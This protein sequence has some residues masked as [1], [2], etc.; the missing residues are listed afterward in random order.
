MSFIPKGRVKQVGE[1]RRVNGF[2]TKRAYE[3][4]GRDETGERIVGG[5]V[6]WDRCD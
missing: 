6:V 4:G 3:T 5:Y 1:M 2:H